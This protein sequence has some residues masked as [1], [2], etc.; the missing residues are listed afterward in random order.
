MTDPT[1]PARC[2]SP[3]IARASRRHPATA[4]SLRRFITLHRI[5]IAQLF[6]VYVGVRLYL[7]ALD[8]VAARRSFNGNLDGPLLGWDAWHYLQ[9]AASGYPS[10]APLVGGRLTVSNGAFGPMFPLLIRVVHESSLPLVDAA[11]VVSFLGGLVA[12]LCVWRLAAHVTDERVGLSSAMVFVAL[13]GLAVVWGLLYSECVG[14]ACAAASLLLMC[15]QRWVTAGLVGALAALTSPLALALAA[16]ASVRAL[17]ELRRRRFS[18]A[19][20]SVALIPSGFLLFAGWLGLRY[21][22]ALFWWHLQRQ[23]W[24]TSVDF[25]SSFVH[26]L[27]HWTKIGGQGPA[28]LEW[29]AVLVVAG[30]VAALVLARLPLELNIYCAAILTVL[31]ITNDLGFKPRLLTWAFPMAI[32]AALVLPTA[33]RRSL[34]VLFLVTMPFL[35]ILYTTM[36]NSI[37]QP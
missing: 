19:W 35:F 2:A 17:L 23:G 10:V 15:K 4:G 9:L 8:V 25:G 3:A 14:I 31:F 16:P 28:W 13:P 32:A 33:A 30:G 22:D 1:E 18:R 6:A 27:S 34:I 29:I 26:L 20:F 24:G 36:G 21:D 37:A 11:V 12:T 5:A 7:F